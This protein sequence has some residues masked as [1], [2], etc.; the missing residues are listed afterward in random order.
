MCLKINETGVKQLILISNNKVHSLPSKVIPLESNALFHPFLSLFSALL[1]GFFQ[2][3]T[4]SSVVITSLMA[5]TPSKWVLLGLEKEKSHMEQDQVNREIVS[6]VWWW[7]SQSQTTGC[8]G[9]CEQVHY[10]GKAAMICPATTLVYSHMKEVYYAA[11]SYRLADW[12]SSLVVKTCCEQCSTHWRTWPTWL[13][14]DFVLLS[15]VSA[16]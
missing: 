13:T 16:L 9:H 11:E 3:T 8:S 7:F 10:H 1:E 4:L 15:S 12:P 6:V 5:S 14:F 2:D